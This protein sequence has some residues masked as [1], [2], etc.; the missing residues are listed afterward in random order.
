M[1]AFLLLCAFVFTI[2]WEKSVLIPGVGTLTKLIGALAFAA[3]ALDAFRRRDLRKP[4]LLLACAA[5]FVLWSGL[6]WFWSLDRPATTARVSTLVQLLVMFWLVWQS[7]RTRRQIRLVLTVWVAGSAVAALA[8]V[9]RYSQGLQTYWKRYAAPGFD[10]N[11]LGITVSLA[12]PLALYLAMDTRPALAWACRLAVLLC[13]TAVL[14]TASRTALIA[15]SAAFL[16][17]LWTWR[18]SDRVQR[19]SGV[20]LA[21]LIPAG[22]VFLAPKESRQ[23]IATTATEITRGTLHKRT[24]IWKAGV[25]AFRHRPVLGAG[26][27]AYPDAVEPLIGVP[28]VPGHEYV[29][30]NTFLSVLVETG[31]AGFALYANFLLAMALFVWVLPGT[32]RALWSTALLVWV[33]GASTLTWEHRKPTWLLPALISAQ[34]ARSFQPVDEEREM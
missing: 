5:L 19:A 34:W 25:L 24:Q 7:C 33:L 9:L 11:D 31:L 30:H 6:T 10:P 27:G 22:A 2:P 32:E 4:Q 14:L 29:A 8:T 20:I 16:F 28:P 3:A 1:I 12:I 17:V 18:R 21:L 23:R 13:S 15:T 26:A